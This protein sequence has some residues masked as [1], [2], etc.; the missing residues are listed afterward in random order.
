MIWRDPTAAEHALVD[1]LAALVAA[2]HDDG[3]PPAIGGHLRVAGE[4]GAVRD[5]LLGSRTALGGAV[6][7]LDWRTAPL[8]EV[9]FRHGPDEPYELEIDGRTVAGRVVA[10]H[11]LEL[12]GS[13][14]IAVTGDDV[15]LR[16]SGGRWRA[17]EVAPTALP[18][19]GG[20]PERAPILLDVDQQRAVDLP[21]GRSLVVDG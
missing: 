21:F 2:A 7:I 12:A 14:L 11:V 1:Q 10:R 3:P 9:F 15:E 20:S 6:A 16:A 5:L 4:S 18:P 17:R 8:A 13:A 19:P